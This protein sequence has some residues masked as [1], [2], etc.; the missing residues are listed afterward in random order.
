M[1]VQQGITANRRNG[2]LYNFMEYKKMKPYFV[3][4]IKITMGNPINDTYYLVKNVVYKGKQILAMKQILDSNTIILVEAKIE[5][6][7][8]IHISKLSEEF[9]GDISGMLER[10]M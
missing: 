10:T 4:P 9:L 2:K 8:L 5:D 6:G 1:I 3:K 7:Q